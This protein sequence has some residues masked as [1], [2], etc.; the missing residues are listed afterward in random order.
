VRGEGAGELGVVIG[1][2]LEMNLASLSSSVWRLLV[3]V[4][5]GFVAYLAFGR[6][7][8]LARLLRRIPELRAALL[9]FAILIVLGYALNDTGILVPAIMLGMCVPVLAVLTTWGDSS[10]P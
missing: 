7:H 6:A 9:G 4:A 3:P 5:L 2:K 1:R 8:A 10:A